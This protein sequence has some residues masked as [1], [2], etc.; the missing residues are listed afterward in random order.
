MILNQMS[1]EGL[2]GM[3]A[4]EQDMKGVREFAK[5]VSGGEHSGQ[6]ADQAA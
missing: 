4:G 1:R 6:D 3:V 5:Q 2:T